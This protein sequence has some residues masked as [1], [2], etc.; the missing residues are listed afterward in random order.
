MARV[1]ITALA[2][3]VEMATALSRFGKP[4]SMHLDSLYYECA[5]H[6]TPPL[7]HSAKLSN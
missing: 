6:P 5:P 1:Q 3:F 4:L 2:L 7:V